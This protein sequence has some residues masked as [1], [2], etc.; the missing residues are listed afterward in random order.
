[1][2]AVPPDP[3]GIAVVIPALDEQEALELLLPEVVGWAAEVVVS[4]AG[5]RD[6]KALT[7]TRHGAK[8][9]QGPPGRG[10]QLDRGARSTTAPIL[11]FLHADTHLPETAEREV[12]SAVRDGCLGGGFRGRFSGPTRLAALG[13]RLVNLRSQWTGCPL[14]DQAQFCTRRAYEEV[15]GFADWP[16]LED[17]DLMRRLKRQGR[18]VL[19]PSPVTTSFRR[20]QA[21]GVLRTVATNW[22]I[23][24]L[25]FVG[26]SPDRLAGLYRKVR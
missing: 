2:P 23:W 26:V 14:G 12:L 25:Y 16:I 18:V 6:D 20:Y 1:M 5:S 7:A 8:V 19:L 3:T 22:L 15:G 17:L 24:A 9:V 10:G 11:L 4:D 21:G 13:S